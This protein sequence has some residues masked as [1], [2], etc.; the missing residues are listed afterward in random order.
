MKQS[1]REWYES[2]QLMYKDSTV[3]CKKCGQL[4][5][6]TMCNHKLYAC[7]NEECSIGFFKEAE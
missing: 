1:K 6:E 3:K 5:I 4:A 7:I 2:L